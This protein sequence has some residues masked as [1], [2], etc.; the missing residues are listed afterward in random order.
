MFWLIL[1]ELNQSFLIP[2]WLSAGSCF[3]VSQPTKPAGELAE[4]D[5]TV[6]FL[7]QQGEGAVGQSVGVLLGAAGP[8]REQPVQALELG[9][10]QPVVTLQVGAAQAATVP[11]R[12]F[13][14]RRR[15]AVAPVQADE[16]LRLRR[17]EEEEEVD[18]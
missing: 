16:V 14:C 15:T 11:P 3:R 1:M 2:A 4:S 9:P 6:A 5:Q 7:V 8:R 12:R 17:D 13:G 10:V 18:Q